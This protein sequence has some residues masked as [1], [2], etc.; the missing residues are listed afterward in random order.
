MITFV[1]KKIANLHWSFH[2]S[3]KVYSLS[4]SLILWW[5]GILQVSEVRYGMLP[6]PYFSSES[7]LAIDDGSLLKYVWVMDKIGKPQK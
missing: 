1:V 6:L 2:V 3:Y 7:V 4:L 5:N